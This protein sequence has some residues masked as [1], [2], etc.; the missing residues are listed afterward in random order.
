VL[1][2]RDHAGHPGRRAPDRR[3]GGLLSGRRHHPRS[4]RRGPHRP[5]AGRGRS[6]AAARHR[7]GAPAVRAAM[8]RRA[9]L[10]FVLLLAA[11]TGCAGSGT[12]AT[13]P[14]NGSS[15]TASDPGGAGE[16]DGANDP[17]DPEGSADGAEEGGTE[18]EAED[19]APASTV[20]PHS[21]TG[22]STAAQV[23]ATEPVTTDPD[24]QLP[25]T[26]T[27][28]DGQ[29]VTIEDTSRMLALDLYGTLTE[30]TVGLG[31]GG[32][33]VGRAVSNTQGSL[34]DLPV[35]TENG[36]ELNV[37]AILA[38]EPTFVLM[39]T[40]MGPPEVPDQLRAS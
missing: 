27:G 22:P 18:T 6:A 7:P 12:A 16:P 40:T 11:L 36:H 29:E 24:Q 4:H 28:E 19:A 32:D 8:T 1:R 39:D 9:L 35:V 14:T 31:L 34:A 10:A 38:L 33:L 23:P 25:V 37:E 3:T 30:I 21:L 20:D 15:A 2:G 17:D 5:G 13:D 26:V